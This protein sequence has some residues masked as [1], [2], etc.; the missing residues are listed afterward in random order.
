MFLPLQ[1]QTKR[2]YNN[3]AKG[4]TPELLKTERFTTGQPEENIS[5]TVRE[6][7]TFFKEMSIEV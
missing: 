1:S 2:E 7:A 3:K 6:G 5:R 4:A